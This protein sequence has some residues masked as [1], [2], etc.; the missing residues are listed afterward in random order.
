MTDIRRADLASFLRSR[1]ERINPQDVGLPGGTRRRTPGLRREEVAQLAGIGVTWYTWLEQGR[2]IKASVQVLDA[3]S[4]TLRLDPTEHEH[5]YRLADVPAVPATTVTKEAGPEIRTIID[6]MMPLPV[7]VLNERYD[8]LATNEAYQ[9]LFPALTHVGHRQPPNILWCAF[10]IPDCCNPYVNRFTELSGMAAR[11]R[12]VYGR[13]LGEPAWEGFVR[14]LRAASSEFDRIWQNHE[15]AAPQNSVKE[16]RY[17]GIGELKVMSTSLG[18][19]S[20]PDLRIIVYTPVDQTSR[21]LMDRLIAGE[22]QGKRYAC[23]CGDLR[24]TAPLTL[25]V[26]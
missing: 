24:L 19:M 10:T 25:K 14:D 23:G 26:Q 6:A 3:V 16:F 12:A 5:L 9:A 11:F 8:V 4:R 18:V 17:P 20:D 1:R 7:S 22:G 2:P 15:V 21:D 13:H